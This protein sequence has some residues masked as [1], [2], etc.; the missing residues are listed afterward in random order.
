MNMRAK[1]HWLTDHVFSTTTRLL[2]IK[3]GKIFLIGSKCV[4]RRILKTFSQK[5]KMRYTMNI[6]MPAT[7]SLLY[8]LP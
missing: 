6:P 2:A 3:V 1:Y 5:A 4:L 7:Q 8:Y